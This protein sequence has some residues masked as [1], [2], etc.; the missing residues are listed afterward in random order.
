MILSTT[1][2]TINAKDLSDKEIISDISC[3]LISQRY[4]LC[5]K[6]SL[7]TF[8]NFE[9]FHHIIQNLT[10]SVVM[11]AILNDP[12]SM[13]LTHKNLL[14]SIESLVKYAN[15]ILAHDKEKAKQHKDKTN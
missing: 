15:G 1:H 8:I 5:D 6:L 10:Y 13:D 14:T 12:E 3:E 9:A 2:I 7:N 4:F 11:H